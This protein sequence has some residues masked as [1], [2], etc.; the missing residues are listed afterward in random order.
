MDSQEKSL[1]QTME[2][3]KNV[4]VTPNEATA[5]K[6]QVETTD[7]AAEAENASG[8]RKVYKTKAE[9]VERIK[10]IAHAE[11]I[12]QKDEV[13]YLKTVFYKLHFAEREADMKAYL[14]AGGDP[15]AYQVKPDENENAFKAEM[16]IIKERRAKQF[17]EQEKLKQDNLKKKLDII[18][19]IKNMATSP[20]EANKSYQEF[21]QLQQEWKEI[22]MVPAENANEL[23]RN[24]QLYVEQFYDLLKLNSEAR[25]YDFKKNL[26]IKTKLCEAA[27]KLA[28]EDDVISAFHQLQELHQEYRESGPVAKELRE[29]IW[30]R[31]KA[32]STVI[33]KKHQQHFEDIRAKE[34][35]NLNKK[36]EL[37][38][39][40]EA[41]AKEEN[42]TSADWENHT[43]QIIEIQTEWKTIGFAPQKMN[44]KIFERFRAACDD[45]F[46]RKSAYFTQMKKE[47][48]ENAEKKKAL[49]EKAQALKDSTEWKATSD[50][51][52]ALQKEWK[53]IGMVPKKYGDQLWND[54]LAACNHFFE[55]RNAANAGARNE[56]HA[57]LDK[58][59]AVVEK[60]KALLENPVDDTQAE[61]RKLTEEYNSI[62]HV[63]YKEKDK[64]FNEYHEVLDKIFKELNISTARRRLNN[65]KIN[66]K[67][68]AKRGE[69]A[70]DNERTRLQRRAEQMKQ[71]IQTYEN[72]L[73]FLNASSKK[74]NSLIDEMN[75]KVQKLKDD[76][77]LI[78]Q[79]INAIDSEEK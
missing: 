71:E 28:D 65:F 2:N 73:G 19:K 31:F 3:E 44:V 75:R 8:Q 43:K 35:D 12:P 52:I 78:K 59:K 5:Q 6:E 74:G 42:K 4:E 69:D 14:D 11:E 79:K 17:E 67:N 15:A 64:I 13:D 40:V 22:K 70:L 36:T 29:G 7:N 26:E 56:E 77:E 55:A 48:T 54:F 47:F 20:E 1:E 50:K 41:I 62:G 76:L 37:C 51:L 23:W 30:A 21:K 46:G 10:E 49:V 66:L 72:N 27:E 32:A 34:E 63:P 38:E 33:N 68:V 45:F 61:V 58:K 53:T 60:L 9:V 16:T 39:K 25:E 18:E 57:N 24:Y